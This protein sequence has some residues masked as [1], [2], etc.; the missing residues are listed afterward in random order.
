M[1][2]LPQAL[3]LSRGEGEVIFLG[4]AA[5]G[6]KESSNNTTRGMET[7]KEVGKLLHRRLSVDG[8]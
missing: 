2:F 5:R 8:L 4:L 7:K 6:Q 1:K 3:R